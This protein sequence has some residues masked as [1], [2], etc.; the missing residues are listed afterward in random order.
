MK[1]PHEISPLV[2]S[3]QH[4]KAQWKKRNGQIL[5]HRHSVRLRQMNQRIVYSTPSY[6][7]VQH[8]PLQI[9]FRRLCSQFPPLNILINLPPLSLRSEHQILTA[10]PVTT[11]HWTA[12][13]LRLSL[14]RHPWPTNPSI[15]VMAT[16]W[17]RTRTFPCRSRSLSPVYDI[18][19]YRRCLYRNTVQSIVPMSVGHI[20]YLLSPLVR[21]HTY[22]PRSQ[23]YQLESQS[24]PCLLQRPQWEVTPRMILRSLRSKAHTRPLKSP[25]TTCADISPRLPPDRRPGR[26]Q[27][28]ESRVVDG[29]RRQ[30]STTPLLR[31][32]LSLSCP[33]CSR[34]LLP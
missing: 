28:L 23:E 8:L 19:R 20:A 6:L 27:Y 2:P 16:S 17:S 30:D 29:V 31:L 3:L 24:D 10:S 22:P 25:Q 33:T 13:Y 9:H 5:P 14:P 32:R 18:R 7:L 15:L 26:Q 21:T 11:L 12:K 4:A 34:M 1:A